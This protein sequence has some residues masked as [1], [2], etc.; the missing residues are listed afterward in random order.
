M[1][2]RVEIDG[3]KSLEKFKLSISPGLN[4]LVGPNGS[5]KT[6]I[7]SFFEFISTLIKSDLNETVS[8][9]GGAAAV[10]RK[11]S[12]TSYNTLLKASIYGIQYIDNKYVFYKYRFIVKASEALDTIYFKEQEFCMRLSDND[13]DTHRT[14]WHFICN[15]TVNDKLDTVVKINYV[16]RR[17]FR[18]DYMYSEKPLSKKDIIENTENFIMRLLNNNTNISIIHPLA[19][20]NMYIH[21]V[22]QDMSEGETF[23]IIPSRIRM[24]ENSA[25]PPGIEK[26]GAGL[27]ATL[28]ALKEKRKYKKS[29][30]PRFYRKPALRTKITIGE[31]LDYINLA[32]TFIKDIEP[33]N[34][35]FENQLKLKFKIQDGNYEAL[36]PMS[37]MS[38][39]TLKWITLITAVMTAKSILSIEEPENYLHPLMQAEILKIMRTSAENSI[40]KSCIIMTTHSETLLNNAHPEEV[41]V[42]SM[43]EGKTI[44]S[45]PKNLDQLKD[46]IKNTGFGL[47]YYYIAG[48]IENE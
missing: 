42:T 10:F 24:I 48:A 33:E 28:Y 26:D 25:K 3:F 38:D 35:I 47:G 6:N 7:I 21:N 22:I 46:E 2:T 30:L 40:Q 20:L 36:L 15:Q 45:R 12:A 18:T 17:I 44:A 31:L 41:I 43:S 11:I 5:G 29:F 19:R 27:A 4:I 16:D 8:K 1:I 13:C 32:N 37:V 39:G 34:D 9:L 14:K 23:N